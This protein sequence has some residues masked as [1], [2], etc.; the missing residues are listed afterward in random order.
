MHTE[1]KRLAPICAG[2]LAGLFVVAGLNGCGRTSTAA[3]TP[4]SGAILPAS[5]GAGHY[6]AC[7]AQVS[8]RGFTGVPGPDCRQGDYTKG[9][10]PLPPGPWSISVSDPGGCDNGSPANGGAF[11][12]VPKHGW[13]QVAGVSGAACAAGNG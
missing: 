12:Q 9:R 1:R 4:T 6:S 8:G 5:W 13:V 2:A 3:D 10:I 7:P 11:A